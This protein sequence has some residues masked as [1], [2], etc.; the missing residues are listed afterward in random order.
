LLVVAFGGFTLIVLIVQPYLSEAWF[1]FLAW[2][3][4]AV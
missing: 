1:D 4:P 2:L 3:L